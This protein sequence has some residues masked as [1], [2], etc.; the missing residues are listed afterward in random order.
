LVIRPLIAFLERSL[1][2]YKDDPDKKYI[3]GMDKPTIADFAL[4]TLFNLAIFGRDTQAV[5]K[6]KFTKRAPLFHA[7]CYNLVFVEFK[8]SIQKI[9]LTLY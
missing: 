2:E 3:C 4:T 8:D 6:Y 5:I 7:Y 1:G 9:K